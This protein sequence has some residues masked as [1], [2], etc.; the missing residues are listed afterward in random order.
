M[1]QINIKVN[2]EGDE[3]VTKVN[4]E[5]KD[6][7]KNSKKGSI[8][9]MDMAKSSGILSKELS[10]VNRVK[11]VYNKGMALFA[12]TTGTATASASSLSRILG[13]LR[14]ALIATGIG[15]IAVL[16]GT[17]ATAFLST[18]RGVDALN[19]VLTPLRFSL[20]R[21]WGVL[22]NVSTLL[23]DGSWR[24][25][26]NT[27]RSIGDE[28]RQG[29]EDGQRYAQTKIAIRNATRAL[30]LAEGQFNEVIS[31]LNVQMRDG[32]LS[33]EE[34]QEALNQARQASE[35]LL[36]MQQAVLEQEIEQLRIRQRQSDTS[37]EDLQKLADKQVELMQL[38]TRRNNQERSYSRVEQRLQR[39]SIKLVE[40]EQKA[41]QK[42][43]EDEQQ[44][45]MRAIQDRRDTLDALLRAERAMWES[46]LERLTRIY[47]DYGYTHDEHVQ[48]MI[49]T[50]R[51]IMSATRDETARLLDKELEMFKERY[52]QG[53]ISQEEYERA[54]RAIYIQRN[55]RNVELSREHRSFVENIEREISELR[56]REARETN[57]ELERFENQRRGWQ[58]EWYESRLLDRDN[59]WTRLADYGASEEEL[60]R[61]LLEGEIRLREE[62]L[63][64]MQAV[65]RYSMESVQLQQEIVSKKLELMRLEAQARWD[66]FA[67]TANVFGALSRLAEEQTVVGKAMGV[68]SATIDTYVGANKALAQG[69][70]AGFIGAGAIIATGMA[71]VRQILATEVPSIQGQPLGTPASSPMNAPQIQF[72]DIGGQGIN[73]VE[74]IFPQNQQTVKAYVVETDITDTQNRVKEIEQGARF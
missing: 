51:N 37:D 43:F 3:K 45:Q 5:V 60:N 50:H 4:K 18:Q 33:L 64:N 30:T 22:Q 19:S 38:R 68:A 72:P 47:E 58:I 70:L 52:E 26:I 54:S 8:G 39:E 49:R 40:D 16:V 65:D 6:L 35:S 13:V 73:T 66:L 53:L 29:V 42:A 28:V 69:G 34:R 62:Q 61:Q 48:R 20:E 7:D 17:L 12:S 55:Q 15:A 2:V 25:A 44:R 23:R 56:M 24:E 41:R 1:K 27:F 74:T 21:I 71:N 63:E 9:L 67:E 57:E 10:M 36:D 11:T 31:E 14:L 32:N 59:F 46:Q